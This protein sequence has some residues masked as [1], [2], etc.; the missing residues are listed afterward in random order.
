MV[1]KRVQGILKRSKDNLH[2]FFKRNLSILP[3]KAET[4]EQFDRRQRSKTFSER[5]R[6]S[7]DERRPPLTAADRT[8]LK[9]LKIWQLPLQI[10]NTY[11]LKCFRIFLLQHI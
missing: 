10:S 5:R 8:A 6:E 2:F 9:F 4:R 1:I 3:P 11:L 7:S